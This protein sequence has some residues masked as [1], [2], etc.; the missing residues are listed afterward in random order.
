MKLIV[1]GMTCGHCER[2]VTQALQTL[3]PAV[4]VA[5]NLDT[6]SVY[7]TGDLDV[8]AASAAINGA[9]YTVL[10]ADSRPDKLAIQS[11]AATTSCCGGRRHA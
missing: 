10:S 9:G 2:A 3:N 1:E 11:T 4:E 7:V 5:V 8:A 6:Q